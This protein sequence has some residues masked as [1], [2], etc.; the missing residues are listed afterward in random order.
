MTG[1]TKQPGGVKRLNRLAGLGDAMGGLLDPAL[2]RRGFASRDIIAHWQAMAPRPYDRVA[3][4]DKL[5]WPRGQRGSEGAV[6]YVRCAPG[7]GLALSHEGPMIAAAINRY[8]GYVLVNQVRLSPTP[9]GRAAAGRSA[10]R[11]QPDAAAIDRIERQVAGIG[12]D[13][14]REALRR[15]GLAVAAHTGGER[16]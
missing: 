6:L 4:P 13:G 10:A 15:L 9:L 16:G 7:H 1:K 2:R 5:S 11:P 3:M 8:F 14:L 12:D